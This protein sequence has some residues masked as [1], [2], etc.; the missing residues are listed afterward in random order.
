MPQLLLKIVVSIQTLSRHIY[1]AA[2]TVLC[3]SALS[4]VVDEQVYQG[5]KG[6]NHV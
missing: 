4:Y 1:Y 5:F 6:S 2:E 3:M